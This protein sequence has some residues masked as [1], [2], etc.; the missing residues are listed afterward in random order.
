MASLIQ[1]IDLNSVAASTTPFVHKNTWRNSTVRIHTTPIKTTSLREALLS[2]SNILVSSSQKNCL[3]KA[4]SSV[5]DLC[6]SQKS[7]SH[8]KQI[9]A[10][11]LKCNNVR[12]L[13]FLDTKLVLMYGKCGNLQEAE[14]LFEEMLERSIFTYNA[15]L[16]AYVLNGKSQAAIELYA[17]MRF[18]EIPLDAHTCCSVL[19]ACA[20][21]KDIYCGR[22]IHGFGVKF[23]ISCND[24]FVNAL[25]NMYTKCNDL[26]AVVLLFN[27]MTGRGAELWNIMISAYSMNGMSREALRL[28]WEMQNVGVTPSTYTFVAALQAC[29]DSLLGMQMHNIVLKSHIFS[30]RYVANALVVMYSKFSRIDEAIRVF[31]EMPERDNVSW[32]AMLSGYVQN[33]L[34]DEALKFFHEI[35]SSGQRLDQVSAISV[36]SACGRSGNLVNGM[37]VHACVLK[38]GMEFDLHVANTV[39]DMYAKCSKT[40]FM[41]YSF[42]RIYHKDPISWTTIIAGYIQNYCYEKALQLFKEVQVEGVDIDK[43]MLESALLAC[44]WLHCILTVKEIHGYIVRRDFSDVIIQNT[45]V[46][47]YGDCGKLDYARHIFGQIE[48]KNVVSWTSMITSYLDNGL[49]CEALQLFFNMVRD[50]VELDSIAI[51]TI[52]SAAANLSALRKGKEIHGYLLRKY[53]HAEDLIASSLV[54]MYASCGDIDSSYAVF[55]SVKHRDL[56]IWTSMINAYGLHGH[57]MMATNLYRKMEAKNLYPDHIAFLAL[58]HACSHSALVEEGKMFF[59]LMQQEYKLDPWPEHYACLVDLLG[60]A[61]FLEEAF[62][63]VRGMRPEPTAAVWCA[64]LGACRIH[65]NIEIGEIASGKLLEMDPDNPGNYVLVSNLYAA[66]ERWDDVEKVRMKMK[67]RG[68]KKDPACSWIEVGNKVHNFTSRDRSHPNSDEIYKKLSQITDKLKRDG[69]YDP[70][71]KHVLH[72]VEEEEKVK[73]LYSHSERLAIAYGLLVTPKEKPIRVTK[74]LR[75]C[76]DCHSFTKLVSKFCERDI[77][78]RDANRFHSFKDGEV[79]K[80]MDRLQKW[81]SRMVVLVTCMYFPYSPMCNVWI[82][83]LQG[84]RE[85]QCF[86]SD[87]SN[88]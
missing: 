82:S 9:H 52:L 34:Y 54:D 72:N 69:G 51:L 70:E 57:G 86:M 47:V 29:Q 49:A 84:S 1:L 19:K 3:D 15:M 60:R 22:E 68:L 11:V 7:L 30:D 14:V 44:H 31:T 6:A 12:D 33:G 58:L 87:Y 16:G 77:I 2:L 20:G 88:V 81:N 4:Y 56:V 35:V 38:N 23:G 24:I 46:D 18:W 21:F 53:F 42:R 64:L 80:N 78:V 55:K 66:A 63:L 39:I 43:M 32:N 75:V 85:G 8:G 50:D 48:V 76:G 40:N 67:V 28:F 10:H 83:F 62:D 36:L 59:Q 61:N 5:L 71:T 73:M 17:E 25:A 45:L 26:N 13:P 65:S 41:Y 27:R 74:N 37:E 79:H